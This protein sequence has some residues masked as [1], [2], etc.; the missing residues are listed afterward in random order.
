[1]P[2]PFLQTFIEGYWQRRGVYA[3]AKKV[4]VLADAC[5]K[6]IFELVPMPYEQARPKTID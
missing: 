6:I 4:R 3:P 5:T 2:S 1:M